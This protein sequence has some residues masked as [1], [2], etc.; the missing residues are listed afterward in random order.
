[1][2]L[3]GKTEKTVAIYFDGLPNFFLIFSYGT[4]EFKKIKKQIY[5]YSVRV[6]KKLFKNNCRVDYK[7]SLT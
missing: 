7:Q 6:A 3:L 4:L 5:R 2:Q 1:M